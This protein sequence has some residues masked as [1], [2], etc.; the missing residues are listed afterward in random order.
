MSV[1]PARLRP[2]EWLAALGAIVMIVA[3]VAVHW[4]GTRAGWSATAHLHWLL[5]LAAALGLA[6][7]IAQAAC[8][9]PA[10]PACLDAV[11]SVIA[12]ATLVW[13][14]FRVVIDPQPGQRAGAWVGLLGDLVLLVGSY[15][16]LRQEGIRPED[17]PGEIPVLELPPLHDA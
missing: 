9:A 17:G 5:A 16:A 8:R 12:F 3:L 14:L 4:N 2:G 10:I 7:A 6:V 13:L 1:Q 11:S 15:L